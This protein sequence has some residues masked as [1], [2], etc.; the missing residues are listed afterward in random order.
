MFVLFMSILHLKTKFIT[1]ALVV[2]FLISY[3]IRNI[4][5]CKTL[6]LINEIAQ[7]CS[8]YLKVKCNKY[9]Q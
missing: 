1:I 8:K 5:Q 7:S 9:M 6:G 4:C 3:R 2:Q